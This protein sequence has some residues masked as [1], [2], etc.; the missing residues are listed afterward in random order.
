MRRWASISW[1]LVLRKLE[2]VD[3]RPKNVSRGSA[4]IR[5]RLASVASADVWSFVVV[6]AAASQR[7][8][9]HYL[10]LLS[11]DEP[12]LGLDIHDH[13]ALYTQEHLYLA[14]VCHGPLTA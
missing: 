7:A 3:A 12:R 9:T 11:D 2:H 1:A 14:A 10:P 13:I 4:Q 8:D 6:V 5:T